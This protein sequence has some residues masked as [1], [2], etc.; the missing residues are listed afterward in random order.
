[1]GKKAGTWI[2]MKE[3]TGAQERAINENANPQARGKQGKGL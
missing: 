1:V 3:V 2:T